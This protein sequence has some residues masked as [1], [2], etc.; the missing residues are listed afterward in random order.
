M[1]ANGITYDAGFI[2]ADVSTHEPFDP[3]VVKREMRVIHDDLHC[4]AVRIT[5]GD[6]DR[7]EVAAQHAAEA[8]LEVGS[9]RSP[10]P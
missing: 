4:T 7:L 1:R 6:P 3:A 8:G 5:G 2:N 9:A 10:A